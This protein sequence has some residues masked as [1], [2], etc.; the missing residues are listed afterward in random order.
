VSGERELVDALRRVEERLVDERFSGELYRALASRR[1]QKEDGEAVSVSW[2]R[3][4]EI[5]NDLRE[6]LGEEP[7]DLAQTGGEGEVSR[8]VAQE[9]ERLGWG[10]QPLDTTE[11]QPDHETEP[12]RPP[13]RDLGEREAPV[14][15][16]ERWREARGEAEEHR[17]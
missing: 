7:L 6:R 9:M 14:E 1:W 13:P 11:R 2:Q 10:S 15:P 12:E 17:A 3:A 16:P 5:V 4:E 8:T